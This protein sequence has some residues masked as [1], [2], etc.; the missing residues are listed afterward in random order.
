M[1]NLI[2]G[3]Y[4]MRASE[5]ELTETPDGKPQVYIRLQTVEAPQRSISWYLGFGSEKAEE[6]TMKSLRSL[7]FVGNDLTKLSAEM[8]PNTVEAHLEND[9][10]KSKKSG[11]DKTELRVKWVNGPNDG[12]RTKPL[13]PEK[14]MSFAERM[15]AKFE[16]F[17]AKNPPATTGAGKIPF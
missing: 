3:D 7:G 15:K 5:A 8:L 14:A 1:S 17:D 9:T 16:K 12:P 4:P 10:F 11:E 6:F 2:P 13:A